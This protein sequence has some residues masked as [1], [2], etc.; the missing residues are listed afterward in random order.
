[1]VALFKCLPLLHRRH[2]VTPRVHHVSFTADVA[3]R[4]LS[5]HAAVTVVASRYARP[6][7]H[8]DAATPSRCRRP[9]AGH[10]STLRQRTATP[11]SIRPPSFTTYRQHNGSRTRHVTPPRHY[12]RSRH[13]DDTRYVTVVAVVNDVDNDSGRA[14]TLYGY[15]RKGKPEEQTPR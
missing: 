14:E 5:V 11:A 7:R 12:S 4:R 2:N 10:V 3:Y 13:A 8:H 1:V 15:I 6:P 9:P